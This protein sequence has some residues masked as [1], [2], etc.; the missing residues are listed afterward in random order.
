MKILEREIGLREETRAL[1]QVRSILQ[2]EDFAEQAQPLADTQLELQERVAVVT[3]KIRE[4]PDGE[5]AFGREIALLSRVE[6][7]MQEAAVLLATP[8]TGPETIAAETEAIELLLQAKR[9]NPKGGGGSGGSSPGGG[10]SGDTDEAALA[11]VGA[12]SERNARPQTRDVEMSTGTTGRELPVE[13]RSGLDAYFSN[14]E[15]EGKSL[16]N[17]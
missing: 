7:V 17:E 5:A 11:L 9:I 15:A 12:G 1:E 4:L 6:Q 14:L 2:A 16:P 3:R 10:G 13:F 8:E